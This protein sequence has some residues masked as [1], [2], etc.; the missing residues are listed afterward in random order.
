MSFLRDT[1]PRA[2]QAGYFLESETGAIRKTSTISASMSEAVT[3]PDGEKVVP[4]GTI[5]P[6]NDATAAGIVYEDVYVTSGDMPGPV[7]LEGR[8]YT[9]RLPVAPVSAAQSAL[10][11]AGIRLLASEPET[12]RPY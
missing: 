8:V 4:A 9:D 2:N 10:A 1:T 12:V 5:W 6:A 11:A 3:T 7:V